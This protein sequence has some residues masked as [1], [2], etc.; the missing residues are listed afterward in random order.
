MRSNS[1]VPRHRRVK[2]ILKK[3][4]GFKFGRKR[5]RAAAELVLRSE[6]YAYK[7]RKEKK[8]TMKSLWI[9][10]INAAARAGGMKYSTFVNGLKK[11]GVNLNAKVLSQI[12]YED[13][14]T[15]TQLVEKS[16]SAVSN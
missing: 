15:F 8:R 5:H 13:E 11:A 9:L 4:K 2:K 6:A 14:T 3:A 1:A 10:R 16:K 12:A 7:H